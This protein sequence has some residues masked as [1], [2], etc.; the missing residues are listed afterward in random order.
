MKVLCAMSGGVD[1]T[2]AVKLLQ[3]DGHSVTGATLALYNTDTALA[4]LAA[5]EMGIE[6][7]VIDASA[8]F[9][10][11]V[12]ENF[13]SEYVK[14]RTPNPCVRC[15]MT[16][17]FPL[18]YAFAMERGFDAIATGHY[19]KAE[20]SE[21]Y[22]RRVIKKAQDKSKDQSYVLCG[23]SRDIVEHTLFPLAAIHKT[24]VRA[25]A[26]KGAMASAR[27]KDSQ[28]ICF[29]PDKDYVSFLENVMGVHTVPG[30]F[31]DSFGNTLGTHKGI[32][33]YTVGQRKGLGLSFD[34]PRFVIEKNASDNTVTLGRFE[35]QF[36]TRFT[37]RDFNWLAADAPEGEIK[38]QIKTRYAQQSVPSA[39]RCEDGR[40][41]IETS[42][43]LRAVTA[44]QSAVAYDDDVLL[45]GGIIE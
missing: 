41:L 16:V 20:Y 10:S 7:H 3:R 38:V 19:A 34:A 42:E 22:A 8:E 36:R 12:L 4:Q 35:E 24:T 14:G 40:V 5:R 33:R 37:V 43:P 39:L 15:N 6:H 1:S 2:L 25:E 21:K 18:I 17:K 26:E 30:N 27:V 45:G 13:A 11:N 29:V 23:L 28:D 32:I 9:K 44:G 31:I